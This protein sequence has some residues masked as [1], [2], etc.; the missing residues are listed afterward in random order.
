MQNEDTDKDKRYI[1]YVWE[2]LYGRLVSS[3]CERSEGRGLKWQTHHK[4]CALNV[5]PLPKTMC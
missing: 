4:K 5:S 3:Y 1:K 2:W